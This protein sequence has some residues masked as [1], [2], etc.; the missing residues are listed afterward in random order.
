LKIKA[1]RILCTCASTKK[2][3][4]NFYLVENV[5][6]DLA[7]IYKLKKVEKETIKGK[8]L[9]PLVE[10]PIHSTMDFLKIRKNKDYELV[11]IDENENAKVWDGKEVLIKK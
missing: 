9:L 10:K 5:R 3:V 2:G 1:G 11:F 6:G 4:V 7:T 8:I